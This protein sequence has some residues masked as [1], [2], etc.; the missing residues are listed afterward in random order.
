MTPLQATPSGADAGPFVLDHGANGATLHHLRE[1]PR[2][3]GYG[4]LH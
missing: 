4:E 1:Q 2:L 3:I